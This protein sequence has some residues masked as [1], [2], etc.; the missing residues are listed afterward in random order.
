M[1]ISSV[2]QF[3]NNQPAFGCNLCNEAKQTWQQAP[4]NF[5]PAHADKMVDSTFQILKSKPGLT[6]EKIAQ[7]ALDSAQGT[8]DYAK[9][10]FFI[11]RVE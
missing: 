4:L 2:S 7:H 3:R 6:H 9:Q 1:F 5:T 11:N 8:L 10:L